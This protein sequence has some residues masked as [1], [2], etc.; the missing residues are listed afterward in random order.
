ME[1]WGD[2]RGHNGTISMIQPHIDPH[3]GGKYV[4]EILCAMIQ[5]QPI[6][7]DYDVV[8][9][10][11][12]N[13]KI[14]PEFEKGWH[15]AL[16]DGFIAGTAQPPRQVQLKLR[17]VPAVPEITRRTAEPATAANLEVLFRP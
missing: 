15:K 9:R 2:A 10:Y 4:H 1:P 13:Q 7:S 14:W 17:N 3:Y 6:P 5:Q 11:W 12:Q 16:H 8:T